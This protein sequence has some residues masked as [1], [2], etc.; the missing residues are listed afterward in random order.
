MITDIQRASM[1][2]RISAFLFDAIMVV[3]LAV[4]FASLLSFAFGYDGFNAE[5]ESHYDRYEKEYGVK[6][7]IGSADYLAMTKEEQDTYNAAYEALI[8]DERVI[9]V[10]NMVV[11]LTLLITTLGILLAMLVLEFIV[12]CLF[13]DGR[14]MGKRIFGL[15]LMRTDGVRVNKLQLFVRMLLG[16][17]TIETM[18][19]VYILIMVFFNS[20]GL[21]GSVILLGILILQVVL[22]AATRNRAD[23]HDL[24]AGTVVVDAASQKIFGSREEQMEYI[25]RKQAEAAAKQPY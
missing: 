6:F 23:V 4:A 22:V 9:Y 25:N 2:K 18:I 20:I 8:A 14:T 3:I 5:L 15:C 11:N 7:D 24:L 1:W 16:K 17:F 12:P 21:L 19:P 10:Y 13:G